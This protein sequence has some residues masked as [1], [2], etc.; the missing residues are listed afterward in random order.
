V[1]ADARRE[2]RTGAV[3]GGGEGAVAG[4]GEGRARQHVYG[5]VS[6]SGGYGYVDISF[7]QII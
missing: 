4:G 6:V 2:G 3:T 5:C 7:S 1:I